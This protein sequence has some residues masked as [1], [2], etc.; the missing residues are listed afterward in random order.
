VSVRK[1][2]DSFPGTWRRLEYKGKTLHGAPVYD[3]Y[4]H[5]PKEIEVSTQALR[6]K[7]TKETL[8]MLFQPHLYSRTK[9][10]FD[11]FVSVLATVD[12]VY[13][14]PIYR[15]RSEDTTVVSEQMLIDA[16]NK[17]GGNAYALES[18][19]DIPATIESIQDENSVIVNMGAGN[20]FEEL[21]KVTFV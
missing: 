19:G 16:I 10:F 1:G 4:G 17:R 6:A 15:A 9:A 21:S 11:D 2:L 18:L 3:D 14:L 20:A 12:L 5:H 8:V 7:Y 13:I